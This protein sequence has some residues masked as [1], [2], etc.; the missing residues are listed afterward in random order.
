MLKATVSHMLARNRILGPL[1]VIFGLASAASAGSIG[2]SSPVV[3][4]ATSAQ[5]FQ[6]AMAA[7]G[8]EPSTS[9]ART[10]WGPTVTFALTSGSSFTSVPYTPGTFTITNSNTGQGYSTPS[11]YSGSSSMTTGFVGG[12][13]PGGPSLQP[14]ASAPFNITNVGILAGSTVTS[15]SGGYTTDQYP[16]GTKLSLTNPNNPNFVPGTNAAIIAGTYVST[17]KPLTMQWRTRSQN[18]MDKGSSNFNNLPINSAYLASDVMQLSGEQQ[19]YDYV[20]QM[21]YSNEIESPSDQ[22]FDILA[23]R[24]LFLGELAGEGT[25]RAM[26]VNAVSENVS[27]HAANGEVQPAVGAYAWQPS[28]S[29]NYTGSPSQPENQPYLGSF[30]SFLNSTYVEGGQTHYYY[31][32]SLDQLRGTWGIDTSTDT[33]WA[34]LDVGDGIFAV[35]PEPASIRLLAGGM[36]SLAVGFWWRRRARIRG[37]KAAKLLIPAGTQKSMRAAA[38]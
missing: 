14:A 12:N 33:A 19:G 25:N 37:A 29:A 17:G 28:N 31:E 36:L 30:A 20:L 15:I 2:T 4:W 1:M 16:S 35:V 18:E 9:A 27:S 13:Y 22:M 38:A 34:V 3:V 11:A 5:S 10:N 8:L 24:D 32:H 23:N 26:W 6:P 21:D 7:V